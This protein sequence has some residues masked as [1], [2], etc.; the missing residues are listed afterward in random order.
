MYC[1]CHEFF[2]ILFHII[3]GKKTD[4]LIIKQQPL[5]FQAAAMLDRMLR[6]LASFDIVN[7]TLEKGSEHK[8]VRR[9]G[10]KQICKTLTKNDYGF[11][12]Y[13]GMHQAFFNALYVLMLIFYLFFKN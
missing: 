5:Y 2:Q 4:G 10:P 9:Y 1:T 13:L 11:A 7:C 8:V 3:P 12:V 6:L